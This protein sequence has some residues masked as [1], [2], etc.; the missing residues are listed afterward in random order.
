MTKLILAAILGVSASA[1]FCFCAVGYEV[2][3]VGNAVA[4]ATTQ[5]K[6]DE[7]QLAK[8]F[9]S[10]MD[11][12][13]YTRKSVDDLMVQMTILIH[14]ADDAESQ[15]AAFIA[16]QGERMSATLGHVDDS[17]QALT[18]NETALTKQLNATLASV[19]PAI[20]Q[21]TTD[22]ATFNDGLQQVQKTF[23]DPAIPATAKNIQSM[24]ASGASIVKDAADETHK[25]VHPDKKKLGFWGGL[26]A[27]VMYVR[28]FIP[29]LF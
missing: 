19:P 16:S 7:V 12:L 25:L 8:Q 5:A 3:H 18:T 6:H 24:T 15:E 9:S 1:S 2:L 14:D 26:N 17:I 4:S 13:D 28:K 21:L 11:K 22:L 29:P 10:E 27:G 20:G 23:A